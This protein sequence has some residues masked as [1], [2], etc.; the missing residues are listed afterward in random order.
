MP[1]RIQV[2]EGPGLP[3]IYVDFKNS[4]ILSALTGEVISTVNGQKDEQVVLGIVFSKVS[5]HFTHRKEAEVDSLI[6]RQGLETVSLERFLEKKAGSCVQT[7]LTFRAIVNSLHEN[8]LLKN[9]GKDEYFRGDRYSHV[10]FEYPTSGGFLCIDIVN[11]FIGPKQDYEER[12]LSD[13]IE[14]AFY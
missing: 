10:W 1:E 8:G 5:S 6:P 11:N 9:I 7:T 12:I 2:T 3:E 13:L 14:S 4:Q